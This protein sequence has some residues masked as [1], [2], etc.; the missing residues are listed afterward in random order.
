MQLDGFTF[1][2]QIVN[3][4]ILLVLLRV[5]LYKPIVNAMNEREEKI[6]SRLREA[7]E[8]QEQAEQEAQTYQHKRREIDNEREQ[9][10]AEARQEADEK[11]RS[12]LDNARAEVDEQKRQWQQAIRHEKEQFLRELQQRAESRLVNIVRQ[13]LRD[14]ADAELESQMIRL[15]VR[16][17]QDNDNEIAENLDREPPE[18][19]V[20]STFALSDDQREQIVGAL[21]EY[22][23]H[24]MPLQFERDQDLLCG[25]SLRTG[26]YQIGWNLRHYL[27]SLEQQ[28]RDTLDEHVGDDESEPEQEPA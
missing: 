21:D 4:V 6:A 12:L 26:S 2:A 8:K 1:I 13:A 20:Y 23:A 17:I 27:A 11:R 28:L 25:I 15:F 18:M 7:E 9:V 24:D 14:L 5:V 3:F 22:I 16:R 10:L 19:T